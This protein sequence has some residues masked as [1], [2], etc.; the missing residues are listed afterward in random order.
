LKLNIIILASFELHKKAYTFGEMHQ[1][2]KKVAAG[3]IAMGAKPGDKI[4]V[5]GPNQ[6]EWLVMVSFEI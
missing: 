2:G 1:E 3:L 5:W 6:P 4:A